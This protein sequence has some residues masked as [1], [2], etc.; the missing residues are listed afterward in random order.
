[1]LQEIKNLLANSFRVLVVT[2]IRSLTIA[3]YLDLL[4]GEGCNGVRY[5]RFIIIIIIIFYSALA[6]RGRNRFFFFSLKVSH[7]VV[8]LFI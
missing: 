2:E 7:L 1:L 3:V 8:Q 6:T 5:D 4:H